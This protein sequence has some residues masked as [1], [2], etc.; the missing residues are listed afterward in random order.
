VILSMCLIVFDWQPEQ[1]RILTLASN[2]DEYYARPT[3]NAHFWEDS[4]DIF[5]GRDL[6]MGG[7]WLALSKGGRLAAITNYRAPD[8]RVYERSR[9][10]IPSSFLQASCSA[11]EFAAQISSDEYAGFNALLF[12]GSDLVYCHNRGQ[13]RGSQT[14]KPG[15]YGLSNHLL[16]TPWPKVRKTKTA[17]EQAR[18]NPDN[19]EAARHLLLALQNQ[20]QASPEELPQTGIPQE[21]EQVL[22]SPFIRTPNYG[23]RASSV[24]IIDKETLGTA[25]NEQINKAFFL[26]RQYQ[27]GSSKFNDNITNITF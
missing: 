27:K 6:K 22:S 10:E 18:Q 4:P 14:L 25:K 19:T 21:F 20:E 12:D 1:A 11:N 16:D 24:I 26:E 9:G 13:T 5:G 23:T 15:R 17:L 8:S 2:R 7:T 3:L